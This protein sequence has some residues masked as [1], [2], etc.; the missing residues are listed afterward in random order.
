MYSTYVKSYLPRKVRR[1]S[2]HIFQYV[3]AAHRETIDRI[4]NKLRWFIA[5]PERT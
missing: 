2:Q 5:G 1:R 4:V 3:I